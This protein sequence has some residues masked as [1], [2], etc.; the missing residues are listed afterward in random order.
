MREEGEKGGHSAFE[1]YQ[2]GPI[3]RRVAGLTH[4]STVPSPHQTRLKGVESFS[5]W[6]LRLLTSTLDK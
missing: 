4:V 5:P 1:I 6:M 3:S 2:L